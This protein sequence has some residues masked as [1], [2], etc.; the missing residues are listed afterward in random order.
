MKSGPVDK[1]RAQAF[2]EGH[3]AMYL[4]D[5]GEKWPNGTADYSM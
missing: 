5:E 1:E 4:S 2:V 3:L